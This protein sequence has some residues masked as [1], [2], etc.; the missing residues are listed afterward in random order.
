MVFKKNIDKESYYDFNENHEIYCRPP[1]Y[2]LYIYYLFFPFYSVI[3][4]FILLNHIRKFDIIWIVTPGASQYAAYLAVKILRKKHF[5]YIIGNILGIHTTGILLTFKKIVAKSEFWAN[6]K[7][8]KNALVYTLGEELYN[9][10]K[11]NK[12]R[13]VKVATNLISENDILSFNQLKSLKTAGNKIRLLSLTRLSH[14]KGL[15]LGID[16]AAALLAKGFDVEYTIVGQGPYETKIKEYVRQKLSPGIVK[17]TGFLKDRNTIYEYY[18][19]SDYFL[20]TSFSEGIPKTLLEAQATGVVVLSTKVG[21]T[22][23]IVE[24][25]KTGFLFSNR[26]PEVFAAKI[27]VLTENPTQKE[28]IIKSALRHARESCAEQQV[29]KI[30]DA[31]AD[32]F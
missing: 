8:S 31:L 22:S 14:E 27:K 4:F 21:G 9:L 12:N 29:K 13:C 10:Y 18:R 23:D 16:I 5:V 3:N 2:R 1:Y 15:E 28:R 24:D 20:L 6:K 25:G 17:F 32:Y 11:T 7:I 19:K 26:D 30:I